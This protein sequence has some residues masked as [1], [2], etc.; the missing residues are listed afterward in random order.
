VEDWLRL[1][2]EAQPESTLILAALRG[3]LLDLLATGDRDRTSAAVDRLAELL[4]D[5]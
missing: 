4:G 3:A 2:G 5:R 1:L